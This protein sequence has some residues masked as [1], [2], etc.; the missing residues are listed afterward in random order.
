MVFGR[1]VLRVPPMVG[2]TVDEIAAAVG[3]SIDRFL[4][5]PLDWG[6]DANDAKAP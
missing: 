4:R 1:Y 2:L 5:E 3:P 6:A